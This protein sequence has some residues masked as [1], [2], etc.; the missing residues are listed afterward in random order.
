MAKGK[1]NLNS[2]KQT[3]GALAAPLTIDELTG[4]TDVY[5]VNTLEEYKELLASMSDDEMQVHAV[6]VA[7]VTP[8]GVRSLL[9][10][11]LEAKFISGARRSP[12]P[13]SPSKISKK[14]QEFQRKFLEGN[15]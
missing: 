2:L 9:V 7:H 14:N 10:D 3:H 5:P 13:V 8:V 6:E 12:P 15:Q 1:V 4:Q 11:R